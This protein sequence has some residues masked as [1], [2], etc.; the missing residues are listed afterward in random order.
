MIVTAIRSD[1][2]VRCAVQFGKSADDLSRTKQ[3]FKDECDINKILKRYKKTGTVPTNG[4]S[5]IYGDFSDGLDYTQLMN[6]VAKVGEVF[7]QLPFE[8]RKEMGFNPENMVK[9][10]L[11]DENYDRAVE[12]GL[13]GK[14]EAKEKVKA[15]NIAKVNADNE[16]K[17]RAAFNKRVREAMASAPEEAGGQ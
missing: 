12:L 10:V 6:K 15:D 13:R 3:Q 16:A 1:G 7:D 4:K 8:F 5:P 17:E 9:F 2:S 14:D 11:D